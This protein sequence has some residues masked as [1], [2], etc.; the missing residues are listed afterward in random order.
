MVVRQLQLFRAIRP[1]HFSAVMV[2][3]G[4]ASNW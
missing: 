4:G 2:V 3:P 1:L